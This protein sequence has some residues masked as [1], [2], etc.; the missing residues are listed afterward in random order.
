VPDDTERPG[1][2]PIRINVS[3][4][5][6][7]GEELAARGRG[8]ETDGV[9]VVSS[10]D[11]SASADLGGGVGVSSTAGRPS[12]NED[13]TVRT[14]LMLARHLRSEGAKLGGVESVRE[15]AADCKILT[16][17]PKKPLLVQVVR[18]EILGQ[19]WA[20]LSRSH[21]AIA[22]ERSPDELAELLWQAIKGKGE[23]DSKGIMLAVNALRTPAFAFPA[24]VEAFRG[25]HAEDAAKLG[26]DHVWI[27]GPTD[28]LVHCLD[29]KGSAED[30]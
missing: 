14:V 18:A 9:R 15:G 29:E 27:C 17:D 22:P 5:V 13:L 28:D 3:D 24:V 19:F 21:A 11:W 20:E 16:S 6:K 2:E 1:P 23:R 12:H 7:L 4:E 30:L 10:D 25:R 26:F 8:S